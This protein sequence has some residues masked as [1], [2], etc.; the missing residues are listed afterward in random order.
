MRQRC[1]AT[2]KG[3]TRETSRATGHGANGPQRRRDAR[4][5]CVDF[6]ITAPGFA[7]GSLRT[8]GAILRVLHVCVCVVSIRPTFQKCFPSSNWY[9]TMLVWFA[10]EHTADVPEIQIVSY[11]IA[12][13]VR[14][15]C[16]KCGWTT[17]WATTRWR[18]HQRAQPLCSETP[19]PT[20][21]RTICQSC[22]TS[23]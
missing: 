14:P 19:T 9:Q 6:F 15:T 12:L 4:G 13:S 5:W 21:S 16:Q 3:K 23:S 2:R 8:L 11:C 1:C 22:S 7:R 20:A 10:T 17:S 18:R